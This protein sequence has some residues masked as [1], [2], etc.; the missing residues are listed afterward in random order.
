LQAI[1]MMIEDDGVGFD[2]GK[3]GVGDGKRHL[4]LISMKERAEILEGSLDVLTA[5]NLG[6]TIQVQIPISQLAA[7]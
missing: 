1:T 7:V 6:T 2:P 5:P 3:L 4:G